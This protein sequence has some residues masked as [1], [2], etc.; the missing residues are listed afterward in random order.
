MTFTIFMALLTVGSIGSAL[1]TE[2]IKKWYQNNGKKYSANIV[3][4]A[5]SIVFGVGGTLLAYL[6]IGVDFTAKNII[7]ILPLILCN[8]IGCMIGYDKVIQAIT[9]AKGKK[10]GE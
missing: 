2:A 3:A 9:Q 6:V 10:E 8:W 1:L 5:N 7:L 4:L